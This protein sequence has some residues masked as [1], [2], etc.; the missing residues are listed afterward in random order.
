MSALCP[1]PSCSS[2]QALPGVPVHLANFSDKCWQQRQKA[3]RNEPVPSHVIPLAASVR[4]WSGCSLAPS[5]LSIA[6]L[7]ECFR[8]CKQTSIPHNFYKP[9]NLW[10]S[11]FLFQG[12][13]SVPLLMWRSLF[14][15]TMVF[16]F[17]IHLS[18]HVTSVSC[19]LHTSHVKPATN[20]TS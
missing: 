2:F 3:A 17:L 19:P 12:W 9:I 15:R 4:H 1:L 11:H 10:K 6:T 14:C 5:L 8:L 20:S 7:R 16:F 18:L 13:S